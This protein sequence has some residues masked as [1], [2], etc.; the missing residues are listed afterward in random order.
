ML[1]ST[2]SMY[3]ASY[4]NCRCASLLSGFSILAS[5]L[6]D[7]LPLLVVAVLS[8]LNKRFIGASFVLF[9]R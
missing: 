4:T 1:S 6:L 8:G 9:H 3:R 5:F 7:D 2:M